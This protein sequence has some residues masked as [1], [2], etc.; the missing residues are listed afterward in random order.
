MHVTISSSLATW[1]HCIF[2]KRSYTQE[3]SSWW[4]ESLHEANP[5]SNHFTKKLGKREREERLCSWALVDKGLIEASEQVDLH[6]FWIWSPTL[7][8]RKPL[9]FLFFFF[10]KNAIRLFKC[11]DLTQLIYLSF[12][13]GKQNEPNFSYMDTPFKKNSCLVV[14]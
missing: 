8:P 11:K 13:R 2:P 5:S 4:A 14:F 6:T 1:F 12:L 9:K 10:L 7:S 3:I